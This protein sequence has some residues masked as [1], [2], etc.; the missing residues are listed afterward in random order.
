M[1]E[2][3]RSAIIDDVSS[4]CGQGTNGEAVAWR[5]SRATVGAIVLLGVA[6]GIVVLAITQRWWGLPRPASPAMMWVSLAFILLNVVYWVAVGAWCRIILSDF[7]VE[8]RAVRTHLMPLTDIVAIDPGRLGLRITRRDL[9]TRSVV[10]FGF[11]T[12]KSATWFG[13]RS[14]A[15]D[16]GL[17]IM[18]RV[19]NRPP[20]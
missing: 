7:T 11:P 2:P 13:R 15:E 8:V 6:Y 12:S 4:S 5:P 17:T 1:K 9:S 3:A 20:D 14:R 16:I 10:A 18:D 19:T